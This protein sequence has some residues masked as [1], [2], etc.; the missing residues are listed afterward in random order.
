MK[1]PAFLFYSKDWIEGTAE[2][3]PEEKGV[4]IDLLAFQHQRGYLPTDP[5]RLAK[6]VGIS[7]DEFS[8]IWEV[9]S[10]KFDRTEDRLVNQRLHL[11]MT[12]RKQKGSKNK[13]IGTF[14]Y[15]LKKMNLTKKQEKELKKRFDVDKLLESDTEW[16][17]ERLTE[18]CQNA[19]PFIEDGDGNVNEDVNKNEIENKKEVVFPFES[20]EFLEIWNAWKNYKLK[21]HKFRYKSE[22][23]EQA[24]LMKLNNLAN[25]NEKDAIEIV[26]ESISQGWKG[27]FELKNKLNGTEK[28]SSVA[29][30]VLRD[31]MSGDI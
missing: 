7:V 12:E 24:A 8:K 29:Q 14:A 20:N 23:S 17:T 6:M 9:I 2:L 26:K 16:N 30:D 3:M 28:R 15:V 19:I 21:E 4:Y 18:W 25:G 22:E 27:F 31:I 13:L 5:K 10:D 11:E 1:D